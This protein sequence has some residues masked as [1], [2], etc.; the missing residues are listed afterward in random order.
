MWSVTSSFS[1]SLIV[2]SSKGQ[3]Q[4]KVDVESDVIILTFTYSS[5][6]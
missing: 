5:E 3:Y 6:L 2:Q 1:P 4:Q